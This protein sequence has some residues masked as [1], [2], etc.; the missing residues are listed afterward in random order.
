[1]RQATR[2]CSTPRI[3]A[4]PPPVEQIPV[5]RRSLPV[6]SGGLLKATTSAKTSRNGQ[7]LLRSATVVRERADDADLLQVTPANCVFVVQSLITSALSCR[8]ALTYDR[9]I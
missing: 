8:S 1:M 9:C 2:A 5:L 4:N 3:E 6:D 7:A